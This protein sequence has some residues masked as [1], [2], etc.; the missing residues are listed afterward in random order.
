V[1]V[2]VKLHTTVIISGMNGHMFRS[3]KGWFKA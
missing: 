3:K 2:F 1:E